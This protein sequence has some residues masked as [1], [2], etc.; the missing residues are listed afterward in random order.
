M[1]L[2]MYGVPYQERPGVLLG[3]RILDLERD[4]L[5]CPRSIEEILEGGLLP[6]VSE[7]AESDVA[8]REPLVLLDQTRLGP[9]LAG[10]GKVI[11]CGLNYRAHAAE[12]GAEL[13]TSPLLFSKAGTTIAGPYDDLEL[14]PTSWSD[15]V[16]YEVELGVV[17]GT[18][19]R[20]VAPEDALAYVAGY[21]IVNDV[22]ARDIQRRES[23]WFRAKSYDGFCPVGPW[24][25]TPDEVDDPQDLELWTQVNGTDRQ[26]SNTGDMV[27]PVCELISFISQGITLQPGDLIAT[28]TP[29]GIGGGMTPPGFLRAG[30]LVE[31]GISG[32]GTHRYRV[33]SA[34]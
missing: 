7:M 2:V 22:T 9:P 27:F 1:K 32:L 25:A 24:L 12:T 18:V 19:C 10:I 17:I 14:P 29:S 21:T 30:D 15:A 31:M 23:Q 33:V 28:G 34:R 6:E 16:D 3:D 13:P 20:G 5:G 8:Q 26:R 4:D 11:A